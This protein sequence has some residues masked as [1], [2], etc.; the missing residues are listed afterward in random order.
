MEDRRDTS[1]VEINHP[2][3]LKIDDQQVAA[4]LCNLS[5]HGALVAL[6]EDDD[7][8]DSSVLGLEATFVIKPK[9]QATRKYTGELIRFYFQNNVP[10][11]A[12]RF[13]KPYVEVAD[14]QDLR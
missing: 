3:S 6:A 10:Y 2:I 1:R 14:D 13:W 7:S 11:I 8:V 4:T 12:L 9:G 5:A